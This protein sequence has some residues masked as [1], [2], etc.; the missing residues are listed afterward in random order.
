MGNA[1]RMAET[2]IVYKLLDGCVMNYTLFFR[3]TT[4]IHCII[5][6]GYRSSR[7][8]MLCQVSGKK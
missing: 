5:V 3:V 8:S 1:T 7:S 6:A 4:K 2:R